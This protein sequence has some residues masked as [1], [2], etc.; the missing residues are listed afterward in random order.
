MPNIFKGPMFP[1]PRSRRTPDITALPVAHGVINETDFEDSAKARLFMGRRRKGKDATQGNPAAKGGDD[2]TEI[3]IDEAKEV[4]EEDYEK[5]KEWAEK[6][7]GK[8]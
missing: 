6:M 4:T 2:I 5:V 7:Q 3:A 1:S 8:P